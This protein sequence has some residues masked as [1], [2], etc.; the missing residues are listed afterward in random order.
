M[1]STQIVMHSVASGLEKLLKLVTSHSSVCSDSDG[2]KLRALAQKLLA[3]ATFTKE[4]S[5]ATD[6]AFT[7]FHIEPLCRDIETD[8][9]LHIHTKHL[10][11]MQ[12]LNPKTENLKP[13]QP[14]LEMTPLKVLG[15][16]I[17]IKNE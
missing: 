13:L 5:Y 1:D 2:N 8:L 9:R 6:T 12:A 7:F 16:I 10:A 3:L 4:L 15:L 11:H 17:N 14:F